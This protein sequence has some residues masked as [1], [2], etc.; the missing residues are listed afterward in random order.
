METI[1][2]A[3]PSGTMRHRNAIRKREAT[4]DGDG[5]TVQTDSGGYAVG[6]GV[7]GGRDSQRLFGEQEIDDQA[8]A[9][10]V[11]SFLS[12]ALDAQLRA[13]PGATTRIGYVDRDPA[14]R[15]QLHRGASALDAEIERIDPAMAVCYDVFGPQP[16][17]IGVALDDGLAFG[18]LAVGGIP[19][20]TARIEYGNRWY[21]VTESSGTLDGDGARS[22]WARVR[23]GALLG[24]LLAELAT[25]APSLAAPVAVAIGGGAAPSGIGDDDS[26][27]VTG[28]GMA[29]IESVTVADRPEESPARGAL[30]AVDGERD[31]PQ[32]VPAFAA[33]DGYAT[34]LAD[35]AVAAETFAAGSEPN[36]AVGTS[37]DDTL[38]PSPALAGAPTAAEAERGQRHA[39]DYQ[40]LAAVLDY[41][42]ESVDD[43]E[44]SDRLATL[45]GEITA[46][47][48]ELESDLAML[49]E[50]TASTE[51]VADLESS[52]ADVRA[53]LEELETDVAQL[54]TTLTG[55]GGDAEL[56]TPEIADA[57]ESIAVDTLQA[58]IDGINETL[59]NRI[60]TLW[61][62]IDEINDRIVDVSAQVRELPDMEENLA[63]V[64]GSIEEL[65]T[66]T[67]EIRRSIAELRDQL[68]ALDGQAVRT[69]QLQSVQSE[70]DTLAAD[71]DQLRTRFE[72]VERADPAAVAA[73]QRDLDALQD[74]LLNHAR[75]LE[76]VER[77][78]SDLDDRLGEAF[79]N[80]AKAD[81]LSSLQAEVSRI[82][83][84]AD[85]AEQTASAVEETTA[86]LETAVEQLQDDVDQIRQM[87]D[88]VAET[89]VTRSELD[90]LDASITDVEQQIPEK[91]VTTKFMLQLLG[92]ALVG[93]GGLGTLLASQFG[94]NVI[95]FGFVVL[96]FAPAIWLLISVS[97]A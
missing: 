69:D 53:T 11:E 14:V 44:D 54:R 15:A 91:G 95:A 19:V 41:L 32:A 93:A 85:S 28:Q 70:L 71:H 24:D 1:V 29:E 60:E 94:E 13:I 74:T 33:T 79:R 17:G 55:L 9:A 68:E 65:E 34:G 10:G 50:A 3:T 84:R 39:R 51:S 97:T 66:E 46:S 90:E 37:H 35:T 18:T 48:A 12:E 64:N 25:H 7:D 4:E 67:T 31:G 49:E 62:E 89:T 27:I 47:M 78:V 42:V 75:R 56:D 81:A 36:P 76:G 16:N 20:A 61:G 82:E 21:D 22:E 72:N 92:V 8:V 43:A 2:V 58:D 77:T 80:T 38:E 73:L 96:V 40:Q 86:N 26:A 52:V 5:Q 57:L 83:D 63:T 45:R 88:S 59:S 30:V 87:V 23:Y 6:N